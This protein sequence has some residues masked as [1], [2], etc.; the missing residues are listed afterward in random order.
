MRTNYFFPF[1][2]IIF[3][4]KLKINLSHSPLNSVKLAM[5]HI[6]SSRSSQERITKILA[7]KKEALTCNKVGLP[8]ANEVIAKSK[9]K[10]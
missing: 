5:R 7:A 10:K 6:A 3:R 9:F 8:I 2:L 4:K 1:L